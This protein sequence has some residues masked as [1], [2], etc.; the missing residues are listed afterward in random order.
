MKSLN[1]KFE[2]LFRLFLD[3]RQNK[4]RLAEEDV[5]VSVED[6]PEHLGQ[7]RKRKLSLELKSLLLMSDF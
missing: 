6:E 3:F 7:E 1:E 4:M 5:D 2:L